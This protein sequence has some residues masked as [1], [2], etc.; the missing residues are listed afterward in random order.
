MFCTNRFVLVLIGCVFGLTLCAPKAKAIIYV[1]G[2]TDQRKW[3]IAASNWEGQLEVRSSYST[4]VDAIDYVSSWGLRLTSPTSIMLSPRIGGR[5]GR[6]PADTMAVYLTSNGS[7]GGR[8]IHQEAS[9]FWAENATPDYPGIWGH[10]FALFRIDHMEGMTITGSGMPYFYTENYA[11]VPTDF[12]ALTP[13]FTITA[14]TPMAMS[15]VVADLTSSGVVVEGVP[16]PEPG[17]LGAISIASII[18][19]S[20]RR[21]Q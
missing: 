17:S 9:S 2:E 11:G 16:T 12:F 13:E 18:L 14:P 21:R 3:F 6:T 19:L 8:S 1:A 5:A 7:A 4:T 20:R 15:S 10:G